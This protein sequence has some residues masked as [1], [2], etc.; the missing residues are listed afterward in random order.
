[1]KF[2]A[3]IFDMDGVLI[4]SEPLW[5][6]QDIL[7][8]SKMFP[9]YQDASPEYQGKG[10]LGVY[11]LLRERYQLSMSFEEFRAFRIRY[12]LEEIFPKAPL[13]IG[14]REF[15]ER[16]SL[17]TPLAIG[18]SSV[19]EAIDAVFLHH[20][21]GHFFSAVVTA[22]DVGHRGKPAPD[23]FLKAAEK[24][25]IAP[26]ECLVLEDTKVGIVAAKN[27]KMTVYALSSE[28]N[29]DQDLS[30]ADAVFSDFSS[31]LF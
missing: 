16:I 11:E 1:M 19:R 18:T 29:R 21:I 7:H 25:G 2:S 20:Q 24:L 14:V 28:A 8:F 26:E 22:D 23:I 13:M 12:S 4:N 5:K 6:S 9:K 30:R 3:I 27:A 31:L 17:K 10:H 15:L